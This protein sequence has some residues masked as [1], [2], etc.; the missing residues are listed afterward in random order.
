MHADLTRSSADWR[1][2]QC[3][4]G[5]Q[6][7]LSFI[8]LRRIRCAISSLAIEVRSI[9]RGRLHLPDRRT[10][11]SSTTFEC[12]Y[13]SEARLLFKWV[14]RTTIATICFWSRMLRQRRGEKS[15]NLDRRHR[16]TRYSGI[17]RNKQFT[18]RILLDQFPQQ[19]S[20]QGSLIFTACCKREDDF[21]E[22]A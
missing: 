13:T 19:F 12:G 21:G 14:G 9:T 17:L 20:R 11:T 8:P 3:G 2:A 1:S 22:G 5:K 18:I 10:A 16:Q 6:Q 15:V 4:N 7:P